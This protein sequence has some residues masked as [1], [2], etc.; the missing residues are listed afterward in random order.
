VS[1]TTIPV[2]GDGWN[3]LVRFYRPRPEF[4]DGTWVLPTLEPSQPSQPAS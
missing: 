1:R 4:F 2:P 3:Y